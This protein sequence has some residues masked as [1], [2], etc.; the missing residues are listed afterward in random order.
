ME[1]IGFDNTWALVLRGVVVLMDQST[2]N[3]MKRGRNV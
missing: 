2:M 3:D 1:V